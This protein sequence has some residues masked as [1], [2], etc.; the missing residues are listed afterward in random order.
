MGIVKV[1][2]VSATIGTSGVAF[3]VTDQPS[4]D[5]KRRIHT[6]CHAVPKRWHFTGVTQA[7]G[8][9]LRWFRD[10]FAESESYD[11]L[12]EQAAKISVGADNLL[13]TQYLMGERTPHIDPLARASLVGL[14]ASHTKAHV[15]RAILEGVVFS[16]RDSI[17]IFKELDIP[18]ESIKLGGA[19]KSPLWRQIQADVYGQQA[20]TIAA[21]EGAAYGAALLAGV[22]FSA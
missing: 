7:A 9:S 16:L 2:A 18:I 22:G 12:V 3:A 11:D 20:E 14:T 10:N 8:L 13:W 19:A 6:F 17:E 4:I 1:G 15:V 5:L 21:E